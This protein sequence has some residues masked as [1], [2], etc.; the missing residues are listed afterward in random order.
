MGPDDAGVRRR[1]LKGRPPRMF[2]PLRVIK[3]LGWLASTDPAKR[4][5]VRKE[6][7]RLSVGLFGDFY[8][9]DDSKLWRE[10]KQFRETFKVLSPHNYYSE[11]RKFAL[12]E[13][14]RLTAGLDGCLAECGANVGVSAYFM[15][16]E[17][18]TTEL[19]LFDSFEGLSEP[20]EID[21][22]PAGIQTW[23]RGD[24]SADEEI[25]R[26]NLKEFSNI[27]I[28]KGW[29]PDR[30]SDVADRRFRLVHI[31]V[32]LYEPTQDS[33]EFFYP[34][35]VAGGV[36]VM[37]DYGFLTCPG[38]FQAAE[39]FMEDKPEHIVHLPTGQ[40]VIIRGTVDTGPR[41]LGL[42]RS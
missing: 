31:D 10:D 41:P 7:A 30:F 17:A 29:I 6:L 21:A 1:G 35:L 36:I 34:R 28:L 33:L 16:E 12:R 11:E 13:F 9:G 3:A 26:E 5:R 27:T 22:A 18:P 2:S 14:V 8:L 4:A 40:G 15:A 37:D 20:A 24:M 25:L 19:F 42:P 23:R 39:S 32:D 38:A